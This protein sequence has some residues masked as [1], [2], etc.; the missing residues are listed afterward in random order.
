MKKLFNLILLLAIISCG[1]DGAPTPP[2]KESSLILQLSGLIYLGENK[3][4]II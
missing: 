2:E 4:F 1:I 3:N